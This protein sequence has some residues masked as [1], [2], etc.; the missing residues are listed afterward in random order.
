DTLFKSSSSSLNFD[1]VQEHDSVQSFELEEDLSFWKDHNVQVIIRIHPLSNY[2]IS[3]QD[4]SKCV[5]QD[6]SQ[7]ITWSGPPESRFT[8]DHVADENVT[9]VKKPIQ[10]C[11]IAYGRELN[12]WL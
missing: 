12:G 3:I 2:E 5:R 7:T 4:N 6:S 1:E 9:Q 11:R 10:S 8:F